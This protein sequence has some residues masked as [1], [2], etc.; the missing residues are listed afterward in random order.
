MVHRI[1]F[2]PLNPDRGSADRYREH[3]AYK[4]DRQ[5]CLPYHAIR[6]GT[7]GPFAKEG[8]RALE[9]FERPWSSSEK[10]SEL[11]RI[12]SKSGFTP[13]WS[14]CGG[15]PEKTSNEKYH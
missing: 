5:E 2:P 1:A 14:P 12:S 3:R 15:P 13:T 8:A 11:W 4:P 7:H 10:I 6:T 9:H